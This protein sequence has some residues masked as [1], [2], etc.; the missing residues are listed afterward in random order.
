MIITVNMAPTLGALLIIGVLTTMPYY[1]FVGSGWMKT[2]SHPFLLGV[3]AVALTLTTALFG[4]FIMNISEIKPFA[5][6]ISEGMGVLVSMSM[7]RFGEM[8][9][10]ASP[11]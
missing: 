4:S 11:R 6:M 8:M 3:L 5:G 9:K 7:W 2:S 10:N 1:V